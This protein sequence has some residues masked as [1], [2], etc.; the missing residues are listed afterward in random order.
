MFYVGLNR[1]NIPKELMELPGFPYPEEW[2][3]YITRQH[4]L[5]HLNNYI[6]HFD[7]RKYIKVLL[8]R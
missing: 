5:Q 1:V 7:I 2:P 4:V 8:S 3:S 6:D